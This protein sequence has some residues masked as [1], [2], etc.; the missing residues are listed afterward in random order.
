LDVMQVKVSSG[1]ESQADRRVALSTAF[2]DLQPW[3]SRQRTQKYSFKMLQACDS[4]SSAASQLNSRVQAWRCDDTAD[5]TWKML[6]KTPLA[7]AEDPVVCP[8]SLV[9]WCVRYMYRQGYVIVGHLSVWGC[10]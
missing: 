7:A 8:G 4:I 3:M 10:S 6:H 1:T 9:V 2:Q 5:S